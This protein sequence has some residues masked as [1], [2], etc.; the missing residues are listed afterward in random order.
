MVTWSYFLE[1]FQK[2]EI[3]KKAVSGKWCLDSNDSDPWYFVFSPF[4]LSS[5]S[6]DRPAWFST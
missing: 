1:V 4:P 3:L 5:V 2:N 6:Y